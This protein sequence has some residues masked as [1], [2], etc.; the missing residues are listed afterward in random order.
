MNITTDKIQLNCEPKKRK[1]TKSRRHVCL[2]GLSK[3]RRRK[4]IKNKRLLRRWSRCDQSEMD[5]RWGQW[6][7][8]SICSQSCDLGRNY[9]R[10]DCI[11]GKNRK[12]CIGEQIQTRP[13]FKSKCQTIQSTEIPLTNY[14]TT[15]AL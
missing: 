4:I 8:W 2:E 13:C 12:G 14:W 3:R 10:R 6:G 7:K 1:S 11:V 5:S 9:R 15:D